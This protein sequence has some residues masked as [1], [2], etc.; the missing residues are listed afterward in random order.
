MLDID[1]LR[2]LGS[3]LAAPGIGYTLDLYGVD[4]AA[5]AA[6]E[7]ETGHRAVYSVA[8]GD[9]ITDDYLPPALVAWLRKEDKRP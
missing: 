7:Y 4:G 5:V 1:A 6:V 9:E 3:D 8:T 2:A